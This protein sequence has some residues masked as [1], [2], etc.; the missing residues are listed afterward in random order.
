M[1]KEQRQYDNILIPSVIRF[2][3]VTVAGVE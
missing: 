3:N 1:S 2:E